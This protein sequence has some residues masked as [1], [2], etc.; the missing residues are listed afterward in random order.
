MMLDN[1][2]NTCYNT[3]MKN[4]SFVKFDGVYSRG[5]TKIGLNKSGLIRLSSGFCRITNI[6]KFKYVVLYYDNANKAIAFK[7]TNQREDGVLSV[8]KDTTGATV[9]AKS[10]MNANKLELRSYFGRYG[11][12]K[13]TIT[14]IGD[15]FIIELGRK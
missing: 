7:F 1:C 5:D 6:T 3:G 14:S 11:W 9:S 2:C 15:V 13:Q 8:T 4:Y 12:E 10:F